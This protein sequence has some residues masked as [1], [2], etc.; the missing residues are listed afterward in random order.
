ML[1]WLMRRNLHSS[2]T[3][4]IMNVHCDCLFQPSVCTICSKIGKRRCFIE[5]SPLCDKFFIEVAA[6]SLSFRFSWMAVGM[7]FSETVCEWKISPRVSGREKLTVFDVTPAIV[8]SLDGVCN[9]QKLCRFSFGRTC[10]L[11]DTVTV[12]SRLVWDCYSEIGFASEACMMHGATAGCLSVGWFLFCGVLYSCFFTVL[13]CCRRQATS[14]LLRR[15][16]CSITALINPLTRAFRRADI[17]PMRPMLDL[18]PIIRHIDPVGM[19]S[20]KD[21]LQGVSTRE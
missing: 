19:K 8:G 14:A 1:K 17:A 3:V 13:R 18:L 7:Q 21:Q 15:L 11:L 5:T 20:R 9:L 4:A 16:P 6:V 10:K 2:Q 12:W